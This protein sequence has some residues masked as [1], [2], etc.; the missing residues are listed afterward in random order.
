MDELFREKAA[1]NNVIRRMGEKETCNFFTDEGLLPGLCF[2]GG[3]DYL[4]VGDPI[5]EIK[6]G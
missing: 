6:T 5:A 1:L 2:S 4:T 3:G